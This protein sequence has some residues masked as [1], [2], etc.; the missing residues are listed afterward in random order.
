M[1]IIEFFINYWDFYLFIGY[2][3]SVDLYYEIREYNEFFE[4]K[5]VTYGL[6][7]CASMLIMWPVRLIGMIRG[8]QS[9]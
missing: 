6:L 5:G 4:S 7:Y 1:N 9:V 8:M 2:W 3:F